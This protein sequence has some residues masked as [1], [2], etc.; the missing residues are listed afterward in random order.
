MCQTEGSKQRSFLFEIPGCGVK[1]PKRRRTPRRSRAVRNFLGCEAPGMRKTARAEQ[2]VFYA[3]TASQ[4]P[5]RSDHEAVGVHDFL[6]AGS[7]CVR[8]ETDAGCNQLARYKQ[9]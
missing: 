4:N 5:R 9:H 7:K 1:A 8:T 2:W 6:G 3:S